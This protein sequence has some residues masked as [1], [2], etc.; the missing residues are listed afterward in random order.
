MSLEVSNPTRLE[1]SAHA[2]TTLCY[3]RPVQKRVAGGASDVL[4]RPP[5][6]RGIIRIIY[7]SVMRLLSTCDMPQG[8]PR[9]HRHARQP[10]L[11]RQAVA[12]RVVYDIRSSTVVP[13]DLQQS[14]EPDVGTWLVWVG[15]G[16]GSGPEMSHCWSSAGT[17][18]HP[19]QVRGADRVWRGRSKR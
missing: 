19:V 11:V 6:P 14:C 10:G 8:W 3:P 9:R 4:A 2:A 18:A 1:H 5:A 7:I 16:R 13:P 12:K 17:D 15:I